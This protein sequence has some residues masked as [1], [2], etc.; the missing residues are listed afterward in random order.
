MDV[1]T[2]LQAFIAWVS[3]QQGIEGVALA[4][5]RARD[6]ATEHSDVDLI[7]VTSERDE[8]FQSFHWLSQFGEVQCCQ[9]ETW[10]AVETI[11]AKYTNGLEVEYNFA[12]PTWADVPLDPGT[13]R[14][15]SEGFR[16]LFDPKGIL[17]ALK[18]QVSL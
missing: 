14:V 18:H 8:Y 11:R 7:I 3:K 12:D 6:A 2:F 15:V 16:I 9:R 5:S 13:H 17:E 4:G 10:G 1:D